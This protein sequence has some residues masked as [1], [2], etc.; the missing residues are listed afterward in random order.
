MRELEQEQ[1]RKFCKSNEIGSE[2]SNQVVTTNEDP[3]KQ[4]ITLV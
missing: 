3:N 1:F 4:S 2:N